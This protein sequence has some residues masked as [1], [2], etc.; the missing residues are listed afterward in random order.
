MS[1]ERDG[2]TEPSK[3]KWVQAYVEETHRYNKHYKIAKKVQIVYKSFLK[4]LEKRLERVISG[5]IKWFSR[6][7]GVLRLFC[8]FS[9]SVFV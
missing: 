8:R 6:L 3:I 5:V 4:A 9:R 2:H 7:Y 1:H